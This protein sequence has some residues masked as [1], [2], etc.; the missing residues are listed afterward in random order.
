MWAFFIPGTH[1]YAYFARLEITPHL[2]NLS[3]TASI[4][5]LRRNLGKNL[6]LA[7][8]SLYEL[9]LRVRLTPNKISETTR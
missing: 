3:P 1:H 2:S 4:Q 5:N 9:S 8:L 6:W 7:L